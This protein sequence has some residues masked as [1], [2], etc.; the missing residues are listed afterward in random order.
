MGE[1]VG[2]MEIV[3]DCVGGSVGRGDGRFVGPFVGDEVGSQTLIRLHAI[4]GKLPKQH[5]CEESNKCNSGSMS[6]S[7]G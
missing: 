3:G 2:T 5:S 1:E 7:L 4:L 6:H